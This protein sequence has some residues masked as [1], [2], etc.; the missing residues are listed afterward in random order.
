MSDPTISAQFLRHVAHCLELTGVS[1]VPMLATYGLTIADLDD[2]KTVVPLQHFLS[3]FEQSAAACRN[4]HFGLHAGRLAGVDSLGPLGYLFLSAPDLRT[5]FHSFNGNLAAM[6]QASRHCFYE[7]DG[8]A[9]FEYALANESM[10]FRRQDAEY[11]I[12]TIYNFSKNYVGRNLELIEVRFEHERSSDIRAYREYFN[13]DVYFNQ[14]FN[15]FSFESSFLDHRGGRL[16]EGLF[17]IIE[18]HLNRRASEQ[19]RV[20]GVV[21]AAIHAIENSPLDETLTQEAV[22]RNLRISVPTLNRK[23]RDRGVSWRGL[24]KDRRMK[25]AARMLRHSRRS[26]AEVAL[27]VGFAESA[28][29]IRSFSKHFGRT[30]SQYRT[31]GSEDKE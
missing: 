12:A 8:V 1:P 16:D 19:T 9:S 3:F 10:K 7:R 28:S 22:A 2:P 21:D 23:L 25:A 31:A 5:A 20:G 15:A 26:V 27:A 24:V 17:P 6:Q 14:D 4:P 13:C 29:F 18:E 11:S 30:P